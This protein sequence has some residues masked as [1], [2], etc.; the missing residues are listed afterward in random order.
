[1]KADD[2]ISVLDF[3]KVADLHSVDWNSGISTSYDHSS[4]LV[5]VTPALN[6]WVI[7]V[8]SVM[9]EWLPMKRGMVLTDLKAFFTSSANV[10]VKLS[11]LELIG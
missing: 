4:R 1:M 3:L 7:I 6:G 9:L 5:A 2:P 10:L 8:G 11:S